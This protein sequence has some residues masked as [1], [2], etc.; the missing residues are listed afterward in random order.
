[1]EDMW[2]PK[3]K[4]NTGEG[5]H[6]ENRKRQKRKNLKQNKANLKARLNPRKRF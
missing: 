3:K 6:L 4:K 1:M 5:G 2:I